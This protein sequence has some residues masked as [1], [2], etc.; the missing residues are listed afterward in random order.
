VITRV[1]F[2]STKPEPVGRVLDSTMYSDQGP[3]DLVRVIPIEKEACPPTAH[4]KYHDDDIE[5]GEIVSDDEE[6][7]GSLNVTG[8][9]SSQYVEMAS[10]PGQD[11]SSWRDTTMKWKGGALCTVGLPTWC[12]YI[13]RTVSYHGPMGSHGYKVLCLW[14]SATEEDYYEQAKEVLQALQDIATKC[15]CCVVHYAT[16]DDGEKVEDFL[17]DKLSD[18]FSV[19][20]TDKMFFDTV[21][22][23]G[24]PLASLDRWR[25]IVECI[26]SSSF[27]R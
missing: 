17:K 18:G 27:A 8:W 23:M 25:K 16:P 6:E 11:V 5:E 15:G 22:E 2:V 4:G 13:G 1:F 7:D 3:L 14:P 19:R 9:Y 21:V 10:V 24:D 20:W 12:K 26:D